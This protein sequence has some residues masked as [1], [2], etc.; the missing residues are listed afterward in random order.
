MADHQNCQPRIRSVCFDLDGVL[1]DTMPLHA[2]AWQQA[3]QRRGL[4]VTKR[5]IYAWEGEPGVATARRILSR[6]TP[7]H[8][9]SAIADVL[10]D[11]ERM[12]SRVARRVSIHPEL[13]SLIHRLSRGKIRLA[14]VTGTSWQ[15]V[16]R[17]VPGALLRKFDAVITGDR[18]RHG[19]PHPEPYRRAI[20]AC[21]ARP[22]AT[23]VVENAPYGIRAARA[24][25][26]GMVIAWTTSLPKRYLGEAHLIV[27]SAGTLIRT[28]ERLTCIDNRTR[29]RLQ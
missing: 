13:A 5:E 8:A 20:R 29:R 23:A 14:L 18:V 2:L 26:A 19:K 10:A 21:R 9:A 12:F 6:K 7:Y 4:R 25:G 1:I 17:I 24:A 3:L 27:T 11:K 22:Q 28:L 16:R 15:E